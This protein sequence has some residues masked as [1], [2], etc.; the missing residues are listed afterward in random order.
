MVHDLRIFCIL[1]KNQKQN[2]YLYKMHVIN[3]SKAIEKHLMA[4][5]DV[6]YNI[7]N[8]QGSRRI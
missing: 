3:K 5:W 7:Y 8:T 1:Q 2:L 6:V 4:E